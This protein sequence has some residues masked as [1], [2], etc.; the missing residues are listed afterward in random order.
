[1]ALGV[2]PHPVFER[3]GRPEQS[4]RRILLVSYHFPPDPTIGARRWERLAPFVAERG[5]GLDVITCAQPMASDLR[6]LEAVPEG[7][8]VFGVPIVTLPIERLEHWVWHLYRALR[9]TG[10]AVVEHDAST[11]GQEPQSRS[12]QPEWMDRSEVRWR[13]HT[14]RGLLRAYW[15]WLLCARQRAWARRAASIGQTIVEPG[16]HIAVVTSGP[17]HMT[18][19]AGREVSQRTGIPFVMDMRDAWSL[20]G[21]IHESL[22]SP[23][24]F[25]LSR[26]Y[27]RMAVEQATL[28]VA[29]TEAAREALAVAYPAVRGRLIAVMNGSDDGPIPRS[30]FGYRFTIGYA[31][32][33]YLARHPRDLFRA[34]SRVIRELG[35][36]PADFG[37]DFI[38]AGSLLE[39]AREEG[40]ADF[41]SSGPARPHAEALEF[42]ARST[43][44]AIFPGG[45]PIT[46]P[47]KI[48]E[49]V[50]F[51]AWLLVLC[52]A[53]SATDRLLRGINADV[54]EPNDITAIATVIRRRYEEYRRGVRPVRPVA[55]DRFSRRTQARILFDAMAGL[56]PQEDGNLDGSRSGHN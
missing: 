14:S 51:D 8:R 25:R 15:A 40:V 38:G 33:I 49:C 17:P 30:T 10:G 54:V 2:R 50:L 20:S 39:M 32:T 4:R 35:L 5:W 44:L 56:L 46:I 16:L 18:H 55:D 31:G 13:L 6:R 7:V 45:D 41:V 22:A 47:A 36:G 53:G 23:L 21:W 48:F 24:W 27:E 3:P 43:M 28:V 37:I 29:N 19:E 11:Q 12:T 1:L 26:R 42:L 52:D 34:A 9:D